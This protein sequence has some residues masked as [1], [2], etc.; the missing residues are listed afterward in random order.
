M[1]II[2]NFVQ[3]HEYLHLSLEAYRALL[4]RAR[5]SFF[6][7]NSDALVGFMELW[8]QQNNSGHGLSTKEC[9]VG[10]EC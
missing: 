8:G 1:K 4:L 3:V 9:K 6:I 5:E 2:Y 7:Q 10:D